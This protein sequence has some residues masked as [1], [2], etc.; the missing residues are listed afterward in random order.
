MPLY[1]DVHR[2]L[3]AVTPKAVEEMRKRDLAAQ[4]KHGVK[5]LKYWANENPGRLFCL[6][7]A[8]TKEAA[9]D[10]HREAHGS[11]A[12]EIYEVWEGS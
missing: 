3:R 4:D 11:T 5:Y 12:A 7:E 9:Y 10:V 8:P 1:I 6:V 2:T